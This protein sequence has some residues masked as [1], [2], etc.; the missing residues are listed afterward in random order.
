[1][2]I[3]RMNRNLNL[4]YVLGMAKMVGDVKILLDIDQVLSEGKTT[5][6]ENAS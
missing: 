5:I 6:L 4:G 2:E 3:D 1:M